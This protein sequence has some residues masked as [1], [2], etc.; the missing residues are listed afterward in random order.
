MT[1]SVVVVIKFR[2]DTNFYNTWRRDIY[3]YNK[4]LKNTDIQGELERAI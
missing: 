2:E 3:I 4:Q 1:R